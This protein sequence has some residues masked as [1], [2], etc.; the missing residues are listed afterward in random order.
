MKTRWQKIDVLKGVPIYR[1]K[2]RC[3]VAGPRFM[4]GAACWATLER[5]RQYVDEL[6]KAGLLAVHQKD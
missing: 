2:P 3:H 5:A 6:E 1:R 4:A